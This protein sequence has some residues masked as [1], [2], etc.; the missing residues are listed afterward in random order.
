MLLDVIYESSDVRILFDDL[1]DVRNTKSLMLRTIGAEY[2]KAV[3]KRYNQI[4]AFSTFYSLQQSGI[5]KMESL[6]GDL[7]GYY[8]LRLTKNYRLIIK[9]QAEDTSAES[10]KKCDTVIIKEVIDYH[11]KG[12]KYNW[13]IP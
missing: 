5:G 4:V 8:S 9:P 6:D 7:K 11:G 13:I 10:L 3:K 1:N 12:T 2:T